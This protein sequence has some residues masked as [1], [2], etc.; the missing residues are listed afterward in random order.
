[1]AEFYVNK[2]EKKDAV[3][4]GVESEL[5]SG[6]ASVPLDKRTLLHAASAAGA[7]VMLRKLAK[8]MRAAERVKKDARRRMERARGP[9]KDPRRSTGMNLKPIRRLGKRKGR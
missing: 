5:G 9:H 7:A 1:M 8:R 4:F 3:N 6:F 2:S